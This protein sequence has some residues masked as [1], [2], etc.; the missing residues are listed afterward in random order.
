MNKSQKWEGPD[1]R[2]T[3]PEKDGL[4]RLLVMGS[5]AGWI[6][7]ILA[8][9]VFHFARPELGTGF[10]RY[11]GIGQSSTWSESL[12]LYLLA[13]LVLC[14]VFSLIALFI[15]SR[16]ARR[17]HDGIWLNLMI[18]LVISS[19]SLVWVFMRV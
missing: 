10:A 3:P 12:T 8:M 16:R 17:R 13:L 1:R 6:T 9:L 4:F 15:K 5:V 14:L 11:L 7:F 18:L 2:Q 19:A